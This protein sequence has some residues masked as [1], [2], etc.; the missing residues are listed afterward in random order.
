MSLFVIFYNFWK[1]FIFKFVFGLWIMHRALTDIYLVSP[2]FKDIHF[3]LYFGKV[4]ACSIQKFVT[5][6]VYLMFTHYGHQMDDIML[7]TLS[8]C[9]WEEGPVE[10]TSSRLTQ[11]AWESVCHGRRTIILK[12]ILPKSSHWICPPIVYTLWTS[13]K[14]YNAKKVVPFNTTRTLPEK[15]CGE[16]NLHV[17]Y[18]NIKDTFM[19][20]LQ[21]FFHYTNVNTIVFSTWTL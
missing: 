8:F 19:A 13:G 10:G 6:Y 12:M 20:V 3:Y 17:F 11:D 5:D 4:A 7:I 16:C 18:A 1:G 14:L 15:V 21:C 2:L 9:P